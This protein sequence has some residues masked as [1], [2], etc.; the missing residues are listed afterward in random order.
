M[1]SNYNSSLT[2]DPALRSNYR[3]ESERTFEQFGANV[4]GHATTRKRSETVEKL[5]LGLYAQQEQLSEPGYALVALGGFGRAALFPHSDID[6]L[7]LC[8]N[9]RLRDRAKDPV[10]HICQE[11]WDSGYALAPPLELFRTAPASIKTM[12]SSR[13][14]CWTHAC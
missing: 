11:L 8:E 2:F 4:L 13:F 7:F 1:A 6:L 3:E 12:W 9:E 5:L 14:H 10:R